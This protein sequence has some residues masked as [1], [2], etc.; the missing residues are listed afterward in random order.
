MG[1]GAPAHLIPC[2]GLRDRRTRD[3]G[4]ARST[5]AAVAASGLTAAE[6]VCEQLS[7]VAAHSSVSRDDVQLL[8]GNTK[9]I[10]RIT[11]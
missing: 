1:L 11:A 6:I 5:N 3:Q 7:E 10:L 2:Q 4:S 8:Q 9:Q